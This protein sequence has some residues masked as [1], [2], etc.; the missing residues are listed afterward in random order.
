[1]AFEALN[2]ETRPE[3]LAFVR[4]KFTPTPF[5]ALIAP[6]TESAVSVGDSKAFLQLGVPWTQDISQV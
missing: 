6:E 1:M 2:K 3:S 4:E 5:K